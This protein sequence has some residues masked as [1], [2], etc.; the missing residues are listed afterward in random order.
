MKNL[1][2]MIV[3][4]KNPAYVLKYEK[5]GNDL[6]E[7]IE[8]YLQDDKIIEITFLDDS[9]KFLVKRLK[10][11]GYYLQY[12]VNKFEDDTGWYVL[13]FKKDK[14]EIEITYYGDCDDEK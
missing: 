9:Y 1:I 10:S 12:K 4:Y 7:D 6:L 2:E 5:Y 3:N 13:F 14:K 11:N 8:K